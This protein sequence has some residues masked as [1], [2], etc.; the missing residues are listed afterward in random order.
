MKDIQKWRG[1]RALIGDAVEQGSA[2][3]ER[4]HLA[5]AKRPFTVLEQIPGIAEPTRGIHAI[6]DAV[7]TSTYAAVRLANQVA[8]QA[9]DKALDALD[10]TSAPD[11]A[12][13]T[14]MSENDASEPRG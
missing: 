14:P 4:V 9:I 13:E 7:V 2:A 5:T 1:L 3:I 10:A 11:N 12:G 6:H 8:G